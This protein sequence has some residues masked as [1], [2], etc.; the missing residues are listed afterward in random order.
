MYNYCEEGWP[1]SIDESSNFRTI[2]VYPN[3]FKN[4]FNI[5]TRLDVEI[6]IYNINGKR[7]IKTNE[8][9][10]SLSGYPN[11]VYN[12]IIVYDKMIFNKVIIK[13]S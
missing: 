1:I 11:G 6:E 4:A 7:I 2:T 13:Q 8:K 3:P 12:M 5:D 10:I 9:R